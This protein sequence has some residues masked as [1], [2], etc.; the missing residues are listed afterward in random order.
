[1]TSFHDVPRGA[2][3]LT[4]EYI[5]EDTGE[6]LQ[7]IQVDGPGAL[8]VPSFSPRAVSVRISGPYGVSQFNSQGEEVIHDQRPPEPR[9]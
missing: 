4:I 9:Q 5:A 8:E 6:V 1:M 2:F 3:P 7:Q